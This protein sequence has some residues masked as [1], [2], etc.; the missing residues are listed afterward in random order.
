MPRDLPA[1]GDDRPFQRLRSSLRG[2]RLHHL[3][4]RIRARNGARREAAMLAS[5]QTYCQFVG[6]SRSGHS[7]VGALLDAHPQIA[8]SDEVDAL[9]DLRLGFTAQELLWLSL[10]VTRDQ[11]RRQ[12]RKRGRGGAVYSYFVPGQWQGRTQQLRVVGDSTAGEALHWLAE[13]PD[14]L[15]RLRSLMAPRRLRF[16]LAMRNP[17][18]NIATM[19]L[20]TGRTFDV[21]TERYFANWQLLEAL[22][23][24]LDP[25][26]LATVR[27]EDLVISPREELARLCRFL[28]VDPAQDYLDACASI[29]FPSP[30]RTRGSV[31]W[32]DAQRQR[33]EREISAFDAL[34]GYSFEA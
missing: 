14:L 6:H 2:T 25:N 22:R 27:H 29:L 15:E 20:R 31:T 5:V 17:F 23:E 32:T 18:D 9:R 8:M 4:R 26:E 16:I 7:I 28:G 21:A 12:R 30:S 34:R 11:A 3:Y 1:I 13:D 24:R 10:D 19:M 33:V